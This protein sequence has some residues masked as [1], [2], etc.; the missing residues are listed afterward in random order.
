MTDSTLEGKSEA[1]RR[2]RRSL[3]KLARRAPA[4][5]RAF[6]EL[7]K[8]TQRAGA[9]DSRTKELI[10]LAIGVA[11]KCE[12]CVVYHTADAKA[13]GATDEQ[14]VEAV[15]VAVMMGGGTALMY[16]SRVLDV[17][18]SSGAIG[19]ARSRSAD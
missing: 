11:T 3:G 12:D 6:G 14:I 5:S 1:L 10:A 7:H 19:G 13:A 2:V 4:T 18:E 8:A 16:A 17:L 9:L 15:E